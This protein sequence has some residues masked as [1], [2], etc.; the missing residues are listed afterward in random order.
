MLHLSPLLHLS[1]FYSVAFALVLLVPATDSLQL[2]AASCLSVLL[3]VSLLITLEFVLVPVLM[4]ALVHSSALPLLVTASASASLSTVARSHLL[5]AL[6]F[7]V[8][9]LLLHWLL[10][11]TFFVLATSFFRLCIKALRRRVVS[12]V[13]SVDAR[14][15]VFHEIIA[16]PFPL[17]SYKIARTFGIYSALCLALVAAPCYLLWSMTAG[18]GGGWA[19]VAGLSAALPLR[20][21]CSH[22]LHWVFAFFVCVLFVWRVWVGTKAE[23]RE[24]RKRGKRLLEWAVARVSSV[25]GLRQYLLKDE[26]EKARD[27][28]ERRERRAAMRQRRMMEAADDGDDMDDDDDDMQQQ[29][30]DHHHHHHAEAA[31]ADDGLQDEDDAQLDDDDD[32]EEV[33]DSDED[34]EDE[35]EQWMQAAEVITMPSQRLHSS[36]S[37]ASLTR[38][39]TVVLC[40]TCRST[41]S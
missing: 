9:S 18:R 36:A 19:G 22:P 33:L 5:H 35:I 34:T 29:A 16:T 38:A 39:L 1:V 23:R 20:F 26:V 37:R 27:I 2:L 10:G 14:Q 21:H 31:A 8:S 12:R 30:D 25:F 24:R 15:D 28:E 11:T 7:P 3:K 13:F 17:E 4:G 6:S 40:L 32:D 41:I